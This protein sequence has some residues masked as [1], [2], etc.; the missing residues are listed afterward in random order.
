MTSATAH[1][2]ST[3]PVD[4]VNSEVIVRA[5]DVERVFPG[6]SERADVR[7]VAGVSLE[8]KEGETLGL[9]GESGS[10]KSTLGRILVGLDDPTSGSVTFK[11]GPVLTKDGSDFRAQRRVIQFVFQDPIS[12]LNPRLTVEKQVA[13]AIKAHQ[14]MSWAAALEQARSFLERVGVN[15]EMAGRFVHQLSGGQRQRVVIARSLVLNPEFAVFDEPVSALDLSV[16]AQILELVA[17]LRATLTLTSVF[18]THDLRVV[19][20]VSD[21][22][23]VLYLGHIVEIGEADEIY[24]RP[25]HPYTKALLSALPHIDP[26]MRHGKVD[27]IGEISDT[28]Q[29][30]HGCVFA[31][32]CPLKTKQC[33]NEVPKLRTGKGHYQVACHVVESFA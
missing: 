10:G 1:P 27:V 11:G 6:S 29:E 25:R 32:R 24:H 30:N 21:R 18:I 20:Y 7:A 16:Q 22:I 26:A 17:E 5:C 33:L 31:A 19:R 13:E 12:A 28:P 2:S 23:A 15:R 8:I 3:Y 9:V 4:Q 14:R